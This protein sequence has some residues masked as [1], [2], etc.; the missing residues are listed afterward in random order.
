MPAHHR[1]TDLHQLQAKHC[2]VSTVIAKMALFGEKCHAAAKKL[3]NTVLMR[4]RNQGFQPGVNSIKCTFLTF[5]SSQDMS[6]SSHNC[7][8]VCGCRGRGACSDFLGA[9]HPFAWHP[10]SCVTQNLTNKAIWVI[11]WQCAVFK[12]QALVASADHEMYITK[13]YQ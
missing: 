6:C 12:K 4:N 3:T 1:K 2:L 7:V 8:P 13:S 5:V 9:V 11:F 10:S